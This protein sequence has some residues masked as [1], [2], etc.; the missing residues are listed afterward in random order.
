MNVAQLK[1]ILRE[2]PPSMKIDIVVEKQV[3]LSTTVVEMMI[4]LDEW[5]VDIDGKELPD[6]KITVAYFGLGS[7]IMRERND[8]LANIHG[9]IIPRTWLEMDMR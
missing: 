4:K 8:A 7:C 3:M 2:Y 5:H 9:T 1:L 6:D